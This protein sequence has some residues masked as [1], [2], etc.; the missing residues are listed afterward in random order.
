M[1]RNMAIT[2]LWYLMDQYLTPQGHSL[3]FIA[4][5]LTVT[6]AIHHHAA[7]HRHQTGP[8]LGLKPHRLW[9]EA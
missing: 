7:M 4:F 1:I 8:D 5:G 2:Q 9:P 6:E 3:S